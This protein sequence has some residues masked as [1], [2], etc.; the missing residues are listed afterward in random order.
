MWWLLA[1]AC[2][3]GPAGDGDPLWDTA[4]PPTDTGSVGPRTCLSPDTVCTGAGTGQRGLNGP[5]PVGQVW[6]NT[7]TAVDFEFDGRVVFADFNNM[8]IRRIGGDGFVETL[9]G[10]GYH[11]NAIEGPA[12]LS[13]MENPIDVVKCDVGGFYVAEL[14]AARVLYVD[15]LSNLYFVAGIG[16]EVGYDGDGGPATQ[17]HLSEIGGVAC[18]LD[19]EI[20]VA[21]SQNN[22]IRVIAPDGTIDTLAGDLAPGFVDGG[23][24]EARFYRPQRM[25]LFGRALYVADW[26]NHAVRRLDLDTQTVT[27]VAG[28]GVWGFAGDGGPATAAQLAG[29]NG[30]GFAA[31]G[32]LYIADSDNHVIRQVGPDGTIDTVIGTPPLPGEIPVGGYGGD[33][34]DGLGAQL[35]WPNDVAVAPDGRVW[36]ADT[37]N[38]VLRVW[39]PAR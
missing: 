7:P 17:A 24:A 20:Y 29:P 16:G 11:A 21:D 10:T 6:L 1:L 13:P 26:L 35:H 33:G 9:S 18:G 34:G 32:T 36:I 15:G 2:T 3:G 23:F 4:T 37:L 8:M 12:T 19:G 22:V 5:N 14:H 25:A 30:V 28:T 38:S 31:D 27:T 39:T